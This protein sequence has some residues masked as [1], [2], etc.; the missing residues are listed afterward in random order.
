[1]QN[2]GSFR[3]LGAILGPPSHIKRDFAVPL[4]LLIFLLRSSSFI[5]YFVMVTNTYYGNLVKYLLHKALEIAEVD[6][7]LY[8]LIENTDA[9]ICY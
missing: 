6:L 1:M 5:P 2:L 9:D 3:P 7:F 8:Y 4:Y